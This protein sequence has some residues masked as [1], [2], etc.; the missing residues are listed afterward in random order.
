MGLA[1]EGQQKWEKAI[2]SFNKSVELDM[3][4]D[5]EKAKVFFKLGGAYEAL[6]NG[7]K[8]CENYKLSLHGEFA[9][10]AKYKIETVLEC[11]G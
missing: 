4:T 11:N 1:F 5:A 6:G 9:E 8:A 10:A 3:G 7:T 2:V